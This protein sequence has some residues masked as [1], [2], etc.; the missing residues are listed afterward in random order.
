MLTTD[1]RSDESVLRSAGPS[2][3]QTIAEFAASLSFDAIP[4]SAIERAKDLVLDHLGV[5]LLGATTPWVATVREL[6]L[7]ERGDPQSTIWGACRATPRAAALVNGTAGHSMELDDTHEESL[8]H[9]G[10][11]VL[12]AAFAVAE[13]LDRT[14]RELLTAIVAGY[15]VQC[16]VGAAMGQYM[17]ERGFHPT[18]TCGVFGAAT[19]AGHLLGLSASELVSAYGSACSMSSGVMQF[20]EDPSGT[21]IKRL[22]GGLPAERGLY[23]AQLAR[24]GFNGPRGAIEGKWGLARVFGGNPPLE[25]VT[26]ALGTAFEIEQ[27]SV[28]LYACCRLFHSLIDAI[29]Q[30]MA[31]PGFRASAVVS[32]EPFGPKAMIE[33]HM[34]YR[35]TSTMS[36]QYSLPYA[37]AAAI[38]LDASAPASFDDEARKRA[39]V[40]HLMQ[41]VRPAVDEQLQ[42][43]FPARFAAGVRIRMQDGG[44]L[45]ATVLDATG[46]PARP[47]SR[48]AVQ[49]KFSTLTAGLLSRHRQRRIFD[50]V[51][52][53]DSAPSVRSLTGLIRARSRK[54]P[55][56]RA[57]A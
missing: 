38:L 26:R 39:D 44:V 53:L 24:N 32:I 20:S 12:P 15:E 48:E 16:R 35:P 3:T 7:A 10:C 25:R 6:A 8:N 22:H 4:A 14:G 33:T 29:T 13:Q 40:A 19:A 34:E 2:V 21:M 47:P 28:K 31:Q 55:T 46:S 51:L 42:L 54:P 52:T 37:C 5:A 18:A 56:P 11:V 49:R 17:V 43:M 50:A 23:A 41:L 45:S 30:C 36:A 27:V 9:P 1:T 57:N